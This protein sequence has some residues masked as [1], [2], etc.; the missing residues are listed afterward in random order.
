[1]K[2]YIDNYTTYIED[3]IEHPDPK[4]IENIKKEHLIQIQFIQHERL[5]HWLVTML[6]GIL[7]FI[8]I[9]MLFANPEKLVVLMLVILLLGLVIPY[10]LYY[11]YIENA[12]QKLYRLY[13]KL[14]EKE[15]EMLGNKSETQKLS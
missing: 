8:S 9:A 12:T 5:V 3:Y 13:N 4:T 7:L 2:K 1:M 10:L 11:Y 14:C 15:N 6:V